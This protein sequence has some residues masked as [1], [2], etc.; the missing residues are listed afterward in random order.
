M[1]I[2]PKIFTPDAA[3]QRDAS[4]VGCF[5][6]MEHVTDPLKLAQTAFAALQPGGVFACIT[7]DYSHWLNRALG[8][9][10]PIVDLEH[11]QLFHPN[12]IRRVYENAGFERIAVS[13]ISN[14][15]R[16]DYWLRLLPLPLNIRKGMINATQSLGISG[17]R[18]KF[19]VGNI[20][21]V[22]YRPQN[23]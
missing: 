2:I 3:A 20:L 7:H 11:M 14:R 15:Y 19:P 5:Q 17:V 9:K 1:Y 12:S 16:L 4:F 13:P 21:S 10:S 23:D 18:F 8:K 22:G 6:T